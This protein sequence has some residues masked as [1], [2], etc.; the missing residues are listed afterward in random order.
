M[1]NPFC[2]N[3]FFSFGERLNTCKELRVKCER[4]PERILSQGGFINNVPEKGVSSYLSP[5]QR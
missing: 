1:E 2:F 4:L 5:I 3:G